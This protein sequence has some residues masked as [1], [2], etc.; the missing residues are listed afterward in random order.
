[1][2]EQR[3]IT[4][5]DMPGRLLKGIGLYG[6]VEKIS[7]RPVKKCRSNIIHRH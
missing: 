6:R 4:G 2:W 1:M 5:V 3:I 7:S